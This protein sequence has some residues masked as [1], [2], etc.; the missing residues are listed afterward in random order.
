MTNRFIDDVDLELL[1]L[2]MS[3][4]AGQ[5]V[6]SLLDAQATLRAVM[7]T[8]LKKRFPELSDREINLKIVEELQYAQ[9][10]A[11]PKFEATS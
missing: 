3:V 8:R 1:K 11:I 9:Q 5:R 6:S 10:R 2:R 7:R 4:S